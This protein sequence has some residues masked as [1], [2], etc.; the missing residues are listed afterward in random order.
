MSVEISQSGMSIAT[1]QNLPV[2][3]TVDIEPVLGASVSG[4]VRHRQGNFYGIEFV[5][6]PTDHVSP[7]IHITFQNID[8]KNIC[9]VTLKP[10]P[11]PIF[12]KDSDA[13]HF[14]FGPGTPL[15]CSHHE[16][17]VE[18]CKQRWP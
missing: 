3:D 9:Q 2:R 13:E 15:A 17:A 11:R 18:Y 16:K 14:I 8:G 4:V 10:S 1:S 12:V 6:L 5:N 7:L